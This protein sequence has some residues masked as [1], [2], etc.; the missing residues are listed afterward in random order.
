MQLLTFYRADRAAK[1]NQHPGLDILHVKLAPNLKK[2]KHGESELQAVTIQVSRTPWAVQ[3]GTS[4]QDWDQ[5]TPAGIW[6]W[7]CIE[8]SLA[9]SEAYS[10][11]SSLEIKQSEGLSVFQWKKCETHNFISNPQSCSQQDDAS[12]MVSDRT[13]HLQ[14][15]FLTL[16]I[17]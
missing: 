11:A 1:S 13:S 3:S 17:M 10:E 2:R 16:L 14:A 7:N 4:V 15:Q 9:Y 5:L 6:T 12:W 8:D